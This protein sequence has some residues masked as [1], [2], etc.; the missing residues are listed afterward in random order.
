[1]DDYLVNVHLEV[2]SR[3]K[4]RYVYFCFT[5]FFQKE[6]SNGFGPT[7]LNRS[8]SILKTGFPHHFS[9]RHLSVMSVVLVFV[10]P[11]FVGP[12]V[13]LDV[14]VGSRIETLS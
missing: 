14:R 12:Y 13:S 2:E 7:F 1:M 8:T 3:M 10:R 6:L 5:S 4:T 9:P 11:L